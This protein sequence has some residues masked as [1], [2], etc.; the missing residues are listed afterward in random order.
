MGCGLSN[1]KSTDRQRSHENNR[2]PIIDE[3]DS[4]GNRPGAV[5]ETS[6]TVV[7]HNNNTTSYGAFDQR[8]STSTPRLCFNEQPE[9]PLWLVAAIG[10]VIKDWK[11]R[12][13]NTFQKIQKVRYLK[14]VPQMRK[15]AEL[16]IINSE[17]N[18]KFFMVSD[19]A[20]YL[21]Q[22]VQ[23]EGF[24]DRKVGSFKKGSNQ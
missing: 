4:F 24:D 6:L 23:S 7:T 9:W 12:Q 8:R 10:D 15:N 19:R 13:G 17:T 18:I 22:C 5:T 16:F 2:N 20:R 3:R 21:Q 14:K 11:P 1:F